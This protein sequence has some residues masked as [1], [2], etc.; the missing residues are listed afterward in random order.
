MLNRTFLGNTAKILFVFS[1]IIC[2]I[3]D[4]NLL[5]PKGERYR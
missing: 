4:N 2:F 3:W 5:N 1:M